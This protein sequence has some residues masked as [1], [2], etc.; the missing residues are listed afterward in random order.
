MTPTLFEAPAH[1]S[2]PHDTPVE[3]PAGHGGESGGAHAKGGHGH[4]YYTDD[5]DH[6]GIANWMDATNGSEP[7]T[8][9]YILKSVGLHTF[10]LVVLLAVLVYFVRRPF[11]DFWRERA[12]DIRKELADSARKRDEAQQRQADIQARLDRIEGEIAAMHAT[13]EKEARQEEEQLV[14]R[15]RKEAQRIGEQAERSVR[16]EVVRARAALRAD[17]V[18][19]AVKLAETTLRSRTSDADQAALARAFLQSIDEGERRV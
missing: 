10:N 6:D 19:L 18:E 14:E 12:H 4:H 15:A 16:D 3:A 2:S 7:N 1:A 17:A 13:A 5:D 9:T 8:E 11:A